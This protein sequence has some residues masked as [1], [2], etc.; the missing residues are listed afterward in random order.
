MSS[1]NS[2]YAVATRPAGLTGCG[3]PCDAATRRARWT[4]A[5]AAYARLVIPRRKRT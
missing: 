1:V 5:D 3:D 2:G 4:A